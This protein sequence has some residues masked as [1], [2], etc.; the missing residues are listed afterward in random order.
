[1]CA[2]NNFTCMCTQLRSQREIRRSR[3]KDA[4][5]HNP[6]PRGN[7]YNY[8]SVIMKFNIAENKYAMIEW[9]GEDTTFGSSMLPGGRGG[10]SD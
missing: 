5:S 7:N 3:R 9:D 10:I 4:T 6:S 2:W 8:C 1:M